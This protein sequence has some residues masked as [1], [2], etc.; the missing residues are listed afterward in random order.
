M[1]YI[2]PNIPQIA[3]AINLDAVIQSIQ[4]D[5]AAISWHEK[6]FGRAWVQYETIGNKRLR[7]PKCYN[8]K[9]E[10]YN[11]LPNDTFNSISFIATNGDEKPISQ[12][13]V[14]SAT[15]KERE[16]KVIFWLHMTKISDFSG[17]DFSGIDFSTYGDYVFTEVLKTQVE[18]VLRNNS[19]V[20]S[21]DRYI[22]DSIE[23]VYDGYDIEAFDTHYGMF[24]YSAF[25]F[26]I[27]V[28]YELDCDLFYATTL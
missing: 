26:D 7:V 18:K 12:N 21:I 8:T 14:N 3:S 5:L 10:Y 28:G 11:A 9:K 25:R 1:S 4:N 6:S 27:T 15:M 16:L 19:Y 22:D 24:P 17:L 13:G 23:R 20:K 2:N